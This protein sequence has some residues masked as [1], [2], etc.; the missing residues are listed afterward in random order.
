MEE[1]CFWCGSG[2]KRSRDEDLLERP[3]KAWSCGSW[4]PRLETVPLKAACVIPK[5]MSSRI[6]FLT[7]LVAFVVLVFSLFLIY[8]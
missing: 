4:E 7:L 5:T 8:C 6:L 2:S 1:G 3:K